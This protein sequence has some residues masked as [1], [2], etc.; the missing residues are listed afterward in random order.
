MGGA[1]GG[2]GVISNQRLQLKEA[3]GGYKQPN[4]L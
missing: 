2:Q 4:T 1:A 3:G